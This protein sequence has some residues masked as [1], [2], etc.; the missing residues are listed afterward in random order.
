[1]L[2]VVG[3]VHLTVYLV[4]LVWLVGKVEVAAVVPRV[5]PNRSLWGVESHILNTLD[6]ESERENGT[7]VG[8]EIGNGREN[9]SYLGL[10]SPLQTSSP[11]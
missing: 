9:H 1:M 10:T 6:L 3:P 4:G 11:A 8:I 2:V 5:R 7:G